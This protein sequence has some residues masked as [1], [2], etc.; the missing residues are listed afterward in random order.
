MSLRSSA[1]KNY[2]ASRLVDRLMRLLLLL[3]ALAALVPLALILAYVLVQGARAL[4]AEFFISSY[5]PPAMPGLPAAASPPA[6]ASAPAAA[7]PPEAT[8]DPVAGI[9]IGQV[10]GA[11]AGVP[12]AAPGATP[13]PFA[14]IDIGQVAGVSATGVLTDAGALPAAGE[15]GDVAAQGGV[16][17]GIVG[18]LL[19][20]GA[21]LLIALPVGLLAAIFLAEY[22]NNRLASIVRFCCD[23]LSGA[24][25]IIAGVVVYILLVRYRGAD[26][27]P[28]GFS[29]IAGGVALAIL[30]LPTIIRTT[31][32]MLRL[33][34][35]SAREAAY[36]LGATQWRATLSVVIPAALPGIITGLL[37]AFAR[38]AGETAPLLL[39]VL[40]NNEL[41]FNLFGPIAALPLLAYR[42]TESPF[43][44]EHT[45]AWGA[46]FVLVAT[47]L[48]VNMLTRLATRGR[49]H[50]P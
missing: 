2:A 12:P 34:P 8:P 44:G 20:T 23:L 43:P 9:D 18:T 39:T 25:S 42:Y 10:A 38:G 41:T 30:M 24:P 37:L 17:H 27:R 13:D 15:V 5:K 26:G 3:A 22:P 46:A 31:E 11:A 16:L 19:V 32:E 50:Q 21:G 47:V 48:L 36:A 28:L 29:G 40:G 14:G 33:V 7:A 35:V 6:P 45:L 4:T 49:F 1:P